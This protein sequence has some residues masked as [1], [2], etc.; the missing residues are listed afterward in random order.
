MA[1]SNT[2]FN[3][4]D[5]CCPP[6][7][8]CCC[9]GISEGNFNL[10][11]LIE[12]DCVAFDGNSGCLIRQGTAEG[13]TK[14]T[15][16]GGEFVDNGN[17]SPNN[18]NMQATLEC[19]SLTPRTGEE[20]TGETV[21]PPEAN[22]FGYRLR[23]VVSNSDCTGVPNEFLGD[24]DSG[25]YKPVKDL[26]TYPQCDPFEVIFDVPAPYNRPANGL[27]AGTNCGCCDEGDIIRFIITS[28]NCS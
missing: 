26:L 27:P 21:I 2:F 9:T 1:L 28:G 22:E 24:V 11:Y 18:I 12:S 25:L 14:F 7:T 8:G 16:K 5:C 19:W 4:D 3:S 6:D 23:I 10:Q 17:C 20:D 15:T 13:C